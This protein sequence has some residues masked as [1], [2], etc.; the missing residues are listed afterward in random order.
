M[1]VKKKTTEVLTDKYFTVAMRNM[2]KITCRPNELINLVKNWMIEKDIK[3][4]CAPFEAEWKCVHL[5]QQNFFDGAMSIDGNFIALGAK[6]LYFNANFN[7]ETLQACDESVDVSS[8]DKSP[9][10]PMN[11]ANGH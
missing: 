3:C 9:L 2:K 10:F 8:V 1:S 6:K 5:E 11:E 4:M 7:S